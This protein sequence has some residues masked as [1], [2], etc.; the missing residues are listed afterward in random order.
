VLI[1][2]PYVGET[3][4]ACQE[5][6]KEFTKALN[7]NLW[8]ITEYQQALAD[9]GLKITHFEDISLPYLKQSNEIQSFAE[10]NRDDILQVSGLSYN[11][12][13]YTSVHSF[14]C[15]KFL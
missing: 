4:G 9:L 1:S 11:V 12:T 2:D 3:P 14:T 15:R 10:K 5:D 8:K 7:F 13:R 6:F